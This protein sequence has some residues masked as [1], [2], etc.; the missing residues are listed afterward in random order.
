VYLTRRCRLVSNIILVALVA[1]CAV[2]LPVSY[3]QTPNKGSKPE[4]IVA[5]RAQERR[6]AIMARQFEKAFSYNTPSAREMLPLEVFR[7]RLS[8]V[9]WN[10]FKVVKVACDLEVCD[11]S[12]KID[13]FVLPNLPGSSVVEEK[14]ILVDGEWWYVYRG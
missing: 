10:D 2:S 14:W 12:V 5:T 7:T 11:V 9:S 8:G 3:K 13:F 4:E 6:A 1:G